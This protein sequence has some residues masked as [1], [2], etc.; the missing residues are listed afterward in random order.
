MV[1]APLH[2]D[3]AVGIIHRVYGVFDPE[4]SYIEAVQVRTVNGFPTAFSLAGVDG[5]LSSKARQGHGR[6]AE[7]VQLGSDLWSSSS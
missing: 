2:A 7:F 5:D 3:L 1:V 6:R 4:A